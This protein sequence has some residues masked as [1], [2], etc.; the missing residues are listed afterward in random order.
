MARVCVAHLVRAVNG[1]APL[2]RFVDS[3]VT[4]PAGTPHDLLFILKA[5]PHDRVDEETER[6]LARVPHHRLIVPDWGFDITAYFR[7]ARG[8]ESDVFCFLNSFSVLQAP[9]WLDKLLSALNRPNAGAAGATGSYQGF[10]VDKSG[11]PEAADWGRPRWK[12][13]IIDLPGVGWLNDIR[14]AALYPVFPNPH[15]RTNA[16]A[17]KRDLFLSLH[18]QVT[19]TKRQAY[20]FESGRRSLTR[21]LVGRGLEVYLAGKDGSVYPRADWHLSNTFWMQGQEN[22]LVE[23]NQ[24]RAYSNGTEATRATLTWLAWGVSTRSRQD[25]SPARRVRP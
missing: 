19:R 5:F 24:T 3:Y 4:H 20:Q 7:A 13:A 1:V 8:F 6:Q 17:I 11:I 23:D 25:P 10:H 21:Q 2:Q 14:L 9:D 22:L 16:F 18:P 15:L 12:Q